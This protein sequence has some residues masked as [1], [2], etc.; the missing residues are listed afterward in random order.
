MEA[1][2]QS[3]FWFIC[4]RLIINTS[5]AVSA[6][7]IQF[8]TSTFLV[9]TPFYYLIIAVFVLSAAYFLLYLWGKHYTFQVS[10][11]IFFDLVLITFLVYISGGLRG[12]FYFLYIF[13]VIAASIVLSNRAAYI[14]AGLSSVAFG[15]L[16]DG[17]FLGVI[18]YYGSEQ[19]TG[20]SLGFVLNHIF[21]AWGVFFLV[22]FLMNFLM[23]NLRRTTRQL[24]NAERELDI[25]KNLA[26]AGEVSAQLAHEIR[27]PL[28][29]ISGSVQVL[30]NELDLPDEQKRLMGIVVSESERISQAIEEFLGLTNP[31]KPILCTVDLAQI[32][33]ETITL[34][35][36]SGVLGEDYTVRGNYSSTRVLYYGNKNQ[37]KQVFL[38][39]IKNGLKAMPEGGSF[40]VDFGKGKNEEIILKFSD[41]GA[42][43]SSEEKERVF[44]PFF[45][46]FKAGQGIGMSVVRRIVDEYQ[47]QIYI[48]SKLSK[49]TTITIVLP[50]RSARSV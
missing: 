17:M 8:S 45:S 39:I 20:L 6:I 29:A 1:K 30:Q 38:N 34:L 48:D 16:V 37:F 31:V 9:I 26:M 41:T 18:P 19:L 4:L 2:R 21:I 44:D 23:G 15:I 28:A 5:L 50:K 43:M 36:R 11:Q 7:S 32:L 12:T 42:G 25:K 10:L 33:D 40:G 46:G 3:V 22:A 35:K 13:E 49:G 14:T 27:N 24:K 47:G